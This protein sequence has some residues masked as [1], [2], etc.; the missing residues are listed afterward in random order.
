[1]PNTNVASSTSFL[2]RSDTVRHDLTPA[3]PESHRDFSWRW[4]SQNFAHHDYEEARQRG[5]VTYTPKEMPR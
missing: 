1:M 2:G 3:R 5:E 4:V